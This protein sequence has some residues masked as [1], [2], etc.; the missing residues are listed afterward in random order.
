MQ[1][2]HVPG[3]I[4]EEQGSD[5]TRLQHHSLDNNEHLWRLNDDKI[6]GFIID[7]DI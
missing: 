1:N 6:E 7:K 3:D 4:I 5:D 2:I